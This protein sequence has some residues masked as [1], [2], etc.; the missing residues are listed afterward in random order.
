MFKSAVS[1]A[2][3]EKRPKKESIYLS[4]TLKRE[5]RFQKINRVLLI[6]Y[7]LVSLY[8]LITGAMGRDF[9]AVA[10]A[11]LAIVMLF[12]PP[13]ASRL[14]HIVIPQDCRMLYLLFVFCTVTVGS[15][16]YGYSKIPYWDKV[17]HFLSG[18]LIS[19][20]GFILCLGLFRELEGPEKKKRIL[21]ATFPFFFNLAVAALWEVYEYSL[22][23]F[24]GIDAVNNLTTGVN[25]TMQDIIVC[26]IGG[27]LFLGSTIRYFHNQKR[28]LLLGVCFHYF[29]LLDQQR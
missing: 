5:A 27:L 25:D 22:Y 29:D 17:F 7:C 21:Y 24:L 8:A 2:Y 28:T 11:S 23:F 18:L 15:A 9:Y 10:Q 12:L 3:Y 4:E 6:P 26:F 20:A 13:L 1:G 19:G 16:L 14:F